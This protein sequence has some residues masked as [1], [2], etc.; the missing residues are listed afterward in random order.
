MKNIIPTPVHIVN[1]NNTT[2]FNGADVTTT[3]TGLV[4]NNSSDYLTNKIAKGNDFKISL[5]VN[6]DDVRFDGKGKKEAYFIDINDKNAEICGFDEGGAYYG[7]VTLVK[8]LE[9]NDGTYTLPQCFILD[10]PH[11][12]TRGHFMECRYGSDFMTLDDWKKVIDYM[13]EMKINNLILGLYGCWARQYDGMF[14]E[15]QYV[16]FKKFPQLKTPRHIKYYSAKQQKMIVKENVLPVMYETDYLCELMAY[17][18]AKNIEIVPLFNSLGH[19]T[20]LPRLIPEISAVDENGEKCGF[21]FCTNNPETYE[22]MFSIYDEIIDRYLKPNGLTSFHIGLDEV[23]NMIGHYEDDLQKDKS[24]FCQCDKCRGVEYGELMLQYIINIAKYLKSRGIE[25]L[26]VYH[27]MLF[28][29]NMLT[30]ETANRL[31]AE[32]LYDMIVVEWWSY[33]TKKEEMFAGRTDEINNHLRSIGKPMTGYFHWEFP[34]Q[35]TKNIDMIR[36]ITDKHNFE[37]MISYSAF[38]YGYDYTYQYFAQSCWNPD[39]I[40]TIDDN[41]VGY[42]FPGETGA[43]EAVDIANIFTY[44]GSGSNANIIKERY[45]YY[46]YSYLKA[47]TEYPQSFPAKAYAYIKEDE[48]NRLEHLKKTLD[49]SRKTYHY[50]NKSSAEYAP[51]WQ[52]NSGIFMATC[53]EFLT[54]YNMSSKFNKGET[55]KADFVN[56]LKRLIVQRDEIIALCEDVRIPANQYTMIRNMTIARQYI[57]DL[58]YYLEENDVA[59]IDPCDFDKYLT[60]A[61]WFLR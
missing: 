39:D 41:Y 38:E 4:L 59:Q 52:L 32:G 11:Y 56:E 53:D 7:C 5:S 54:V 33:R 21:G 17:A 48:E 42:R 50:F 58:I 34:C 57:L 6:P 28:K 55:S 13:S 44:D 40:K 35:T 20:L 23:W 1:K 30:E 12:N 2:S 61:S 14:A 26:Y 18:K 31:K 24:P 22:V 3:Q 49:S 47:D 45:G 36:N 27:D 10:Y 16:P 60:E 15:Y 37:G 43:K 19:N 46:G 8:L 9:S 29:H 51:V 25:T